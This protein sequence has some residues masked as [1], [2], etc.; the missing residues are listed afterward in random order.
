LKNSDLVISH[1]GAGSIMTT[2][3]N[4]KPLI[5]VPRLKKYGEVVDD[6]QLELAREMEK[7][8]RAIVAYDTN[9]L[10]KK[11]EEAKKIKI[12]KLTKSKIPQ[13]IEDFLKNGNI[14]T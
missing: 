6:H 11:I 9:D 1:A 14:I 12:K 4:N 3:V 10:G 7:Q 5:L 8:G 2:L 13:I